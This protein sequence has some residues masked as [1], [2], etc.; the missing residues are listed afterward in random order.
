M[1]DDQVDDDGALFG[2]DELVVDVDAVGRCEA[3]TY[4]AL[5][6]GATDGVVMRLDAGLAAV[7]LA[8]A[9][10]LDE[11]ERVGRMGGGVG[12]KA[13]YLYAQLVGP[14]RELMQALRLPAEVEPAE[15]PRLPAPTGDGSAP[16]WVH[17]LAGR[18]E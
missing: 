9:R 16:S 15:E 3:G 18:A 14:Y 10:R 5:R 4:A 2:V 11:A 13:G 7:A 6:Q 8:T 17:D 1:T 12:L